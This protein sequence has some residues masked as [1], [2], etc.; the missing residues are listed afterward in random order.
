[1]SSPTQHRP[2]SSCA[3]LASTTRRR[4]PRSS[5]SYWVVPASA[6]GTARCASHPRPSP[7]ATRVEDVPG[8]PSG[9]VRHLPP[10]RPARL[11]PRHV[12]RCC[13]GGCSP[14][15]TPGTC[16]YL[17]PRISKR[18]MV[19]RSA[20][21]GDR[22]VRRTPRADMG[23]SVNDADSTGSTVSSTGTS[24]QSSPRS[25]TATIRGGS[26]ESSPM[27]AAAPPR[28][29]S[30]S[31]RRPEPQLRSTRAPASP[32]SRSAQRQRVV[33]SVV[34]AAGTLVVAIGRLPRGT[35]MNSQPDTIPTRWPPPTEI[36]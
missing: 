17:L 9:P 30:R 35:P 21:R 5:S 12:R 36:V 25:L 20:C 18:A 34:L 11:D 3:S 14:R 15:P 16:C 2:R 6:G 29:A 23:A 24:R 10:Q 27:I 19:H 8:G 4:L 26:S 32:W 31:G 7:S 13:A 33:A 1:M 22:G 28:S